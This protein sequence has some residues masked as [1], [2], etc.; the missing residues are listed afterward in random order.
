MSR[1]QKMMSERD[2]SGRDLSSGPDGTTAVCYIAV[3][4]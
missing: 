4:K 1:C 3:V 2:L